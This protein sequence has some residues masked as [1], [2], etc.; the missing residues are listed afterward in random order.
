[1]ASIFEAFDIFPAGGN[2]IQS[3]R[4][5]SIVQKHWSSRGFDVLETMG[6]IQ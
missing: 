1:M 5:S 3:N 4:L 6:A 2:F